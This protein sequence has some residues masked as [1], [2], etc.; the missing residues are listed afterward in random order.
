MKTLHNRKIP[1]AISVC[2]K[3]LKPEPRNTNC[4]NCASFRRVC[5]V[6]LWNSKATKIPPSCRMRDG[7]CLIAPNFSGYVYPNKST[8]SEDPKRPFFADCICGMYLSLTPPSYP[9]SDHFMHR[10]HKVCDTF[11]LICFQTSAANQKIC[12]VPNVKC[13]ICMKLSSDK[14]G[15]LR[16]KAPFFT[17]L[18]ALK[19]KLPAP[20]IGTE[21]PKSS[22]P[23]IPGEA[24]TIKK[25]QKILNK[26]LK[27][28]VFWIQKISFTGINSIN[29]KGTMPNPPAVVSLATH[30]ACSKPAR[31]GHGSRAAKP[32]GAQEVVSKEWAL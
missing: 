3:L 16:N 21:N 23:A 25:E 10:S 17:H 30:S 24:L 2:C 8:V 29:G 22:A 1:Q 11:N 14:A 12:G 4:A 6:L 9:P 13:K 32:W 31:C 15:Y 20:S 27:I 28:T 26:H 18:L 5:T 7:R 19:K